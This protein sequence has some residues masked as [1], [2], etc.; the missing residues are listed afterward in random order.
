MSTPTPAT[1][2]ASGAAP[3]R[4][5]FF[6]PDKN[7]KG[8]KSL[9]DLEPFAA[10]VASP[11]S[12]GSSFSVPV[13]T[14]TPIVPPVAPATAPT[15]GAI[16]AVGAIV[17]G[18]SYR[19]GVH[20]NVLLTGG[21]GK[22]AKA[23]ITVTDNAVTAVVVDPTSPGV[24]YVD[25]DELSATLGDRLINVLVIDHTGRT[26]QMRDVPLF[27]GDD[28]DDKT[29]LAHCEATYRRIEKPGIR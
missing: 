13:T 26:F 27:Q 14:A 29:A 21:S 22:G 25:G 8:M 15:G 28:A 11:G 2:S 10:I 6:Y 19:N 16:T 7:A 23:T 9:D 5:V 24:G 17:G 4:I 18:E 20:K 1:G 3:G 12:A